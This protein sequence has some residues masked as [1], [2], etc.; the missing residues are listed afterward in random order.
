[1]ECLRFIIPILLNNQ[2]RYPEDRPSILA[3]FAA[4]GRAHAD[5]AGGCLFTHPKRGR[6]ACRLFATLWGLPPTFADAEYFVE[7]LMQ[8]HHDLMPGEASLEDPRCTCCSG[9]DSRERPYP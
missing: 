6:P 8:W 3:A 5:L 1:M 9:P 4:L 7:S 2:D